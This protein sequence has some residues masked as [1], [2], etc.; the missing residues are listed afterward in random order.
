[1]P[2]VADSAGNIAVSMSTEE[3]NRILWISSQGKLISDIDS[4]GDIIS[5]SAT[6]LII[7]DSQDGVTDKNGNPY[8]YVRHSI[9]NGKLKREPFGISDNISGYPFPSGLLDICETDVDG[10]ITALC[11]YRF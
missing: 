7:R 1:M 3:G 8:I 9:S 10:N 6:A 11:F 5:A 2:Y 4:N